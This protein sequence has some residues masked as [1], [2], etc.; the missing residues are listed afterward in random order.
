MSYCDCIKKECPEC[1]LKGDT[2]YCN[3]YEVPVDNIIR[4]NK[5]KES[6]NE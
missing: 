4:C 6:E 5:D 1:D 3:Y 2:Q